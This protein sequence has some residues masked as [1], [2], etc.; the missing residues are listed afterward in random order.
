MDTPAY[1][2]PNPTSEAQSKSFAVTLSRNAVNHRNHSH[3][4]TG[5]L[6][7]SSFLI[8]D[9]YERHMPC[10]IVRPDESDYSFHEAKHTDRWPSS[11][12]TTKMLFLRGPGYSWSGEE[13]EV[14][15]CDGD[16]EIYWTCFIDWVLFV[17]VSKVFEGW[18][19]VIVCSLLSRS[20]TLQFRFQQHHCS[21]SW[22]YERGNCSCQ[23][24]GLPCSIA[25]VSWRVFRYLTILAPCLWLE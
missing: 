24:S 22:A 4:N 5:I 1:S 9:A 25:T 11:P 14:L 16:D 23:A 19:T 13:N 10:R 15:Y 2:H 17:T 12:A 21:A 7:I 8:Y 6:S 3:N 18:N 20:T